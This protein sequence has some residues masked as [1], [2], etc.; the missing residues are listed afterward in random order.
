MPRK[1]KKEREEKPLGIPEE[2]IEGME[3]EWEET[4]PEVSSEPLLL[5]S[6]PEDLEEK[7]MEEQI[8]RTEEVIGKHEE[9]VKEEEQKEFIEEM[10]KEAVRLGY[11]KAGEIS[12]YEVA[13]EFQEGLPKVRKWAEEQELIG[14][15]SKEQLKADIAALRKQR[16]QYEPSRWK[17][18][19]AGAKAFGGFAEKKLKPRPKLE[20]RGF[21]IPQTMKEYYVPGKQVRKLTTPPMQGSIIAEVNRPNLELLM[22]SSSPPPITSIKAPQ[23]RPTE[24]GEMGSALG[25][26][27][28]LGKFPAVDWAVYNEIRTNG[29]IDTPS[30]VRREVGMLG[31]SR[32]EISDS[33]TRLRKLG[34]IAPTGLVM[35]GEKELE[36]V[37]QEHNKALER[38]E[39]GK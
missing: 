39:L 38:K 29:D 26:L 23:I 14:L 28:Q 9:K 8:R 32:K 30:H 36:I 11:P 34:I 4:H 6:P 13:K 15:K 27:R 18:F 35:D 17:T 20:L 1:K 22:R 21:Y 25:R 10:R 12:S 31:F 24:F 7:L 33:L 3:K 37:G 5:P 2:F 16:K 19:K